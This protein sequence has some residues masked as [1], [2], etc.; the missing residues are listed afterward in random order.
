MKKSVPKIKSYTAEDILGS[1]SFPDTAYKSWADF[2]YCLATPE[3]INGSF[4][5]AL[6]RCLYSIGID[7]TEEVHDCDDFARLCSCLARI[8]HARTNVAKQAIAIG[9]VEYHIEGD[10][11]KPH[12][13]NVWFVRKKNGFIGELYYEPQTQS[14]KVLSAV[15]FN[16]I[17]RIS[18]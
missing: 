16:S 4:T 9:E 17:Y 6:V 15:E 18:I 2:R 14:E 3:W 13:I 8:C 11:R 5:T 10:H 12:M 7:H 1:V